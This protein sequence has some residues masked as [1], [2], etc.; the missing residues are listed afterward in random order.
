MATRGLERF[1]QDRDA[2]QLAVQGL[3]Q[4]QSPEK[5]LTA[6]LAR[7]ILESYNR[8]IACAEEGKPFIANTYANAP[9]LFVALGLPWYPISQMPLLPTSE[10]YILV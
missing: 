10:S 2:L 5:Q 7:A 1:N 4:S 9:E 6:S 3:E 8:I